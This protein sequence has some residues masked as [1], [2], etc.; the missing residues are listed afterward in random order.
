MLLNGY[1]FLDYGEFRYQERLNE[2]AWLL[3]GDL[4]EVQR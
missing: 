4:D 1:Y 2:Q 3:L